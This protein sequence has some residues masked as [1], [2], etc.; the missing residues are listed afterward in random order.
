MFTAEADPDPLPPKDTND[1]STDPV[2]EPVLG[3]ESNSAEKR[4][5]VA[6]AGLAVI[7]RPEAANATL[8]NDFITKYPQISSNTSCQSS[9]FFATSKKFT[10]HLINVKFP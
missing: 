3:P 4:K 10:L 7:A 5:T 8:Q 6:A 1:K 9:A 2:S